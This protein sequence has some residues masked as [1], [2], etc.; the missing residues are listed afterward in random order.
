MSYTTVTENH[1][2]SKYR[3]QLTMWYPAPVDIDTNLH[4]MLRNI[5]EEGR[6]EKT[7]RARGTGSLL[8]E[9]LS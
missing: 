9:F 5:L 6:G 8:E 4:L 2:Q 3:K 1:K 7:V